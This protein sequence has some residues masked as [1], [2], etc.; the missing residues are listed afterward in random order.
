MTQWLI[1]SIKDIGKM[2]SR[3]IRSRKSEPHETHAKNTQ[4]KYFKVA[5]YCMPIGASQYYS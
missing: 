2:Q 3:S 4:R 1:A 5:L